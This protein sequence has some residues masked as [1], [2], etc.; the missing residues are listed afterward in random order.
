[1][2]NQISRSL[3]ILLSALI[4]GFMPAHAQDSATTEQAPPPAPTLSGGDI[5]PVKSADELHI[6]IDENSPTHPPVRMTPDKSELIRLDR[7]AAA[8]VIG[9]PAHLSILP[10]GSNTLVLVARAPGATYFTALDEDG[11]VIMQRH[12]IIAAPKEK[13]VRIRKSCGNSTDCAPTQVYYCPDMCHEIILNN[14]ESGSD[15]ASAKTD[16]K[17]SDGSAAGTGTADASSEEETSKE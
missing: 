14:G 7:K 5:V 15:A 6:N 10:E 2:K 4:L 3:P 13:Y 12:V 9:N 17:S 11:K 1:M 16:S 8:V